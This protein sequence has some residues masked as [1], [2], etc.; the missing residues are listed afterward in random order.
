MLTVSFYA[1]STI[2]QEACTFADGVR[3][4]TPKE[5]DNSDLYTEKEAEL[6]A[7]N[8]HRQTDFIEYF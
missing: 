7:Q 3:S 4:I 8:R 2:D 5:Y 6:A 1:K